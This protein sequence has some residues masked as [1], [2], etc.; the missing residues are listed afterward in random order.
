MRQYARLMGETR[1]LTLTGVGGCG[2]TRLGLRLAESLLESHPDGVYW[3][4]L[5]PVSEEA[6]FAQTLA[7]TIGDAGR[8][9]PDLL[10][11]VAAHV[12]GKRVMLVLDNW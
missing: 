11:S 4:D 9:G 3:V 7:T 2:K 6:R 1:L 12:A 8:S 5:A 10:S